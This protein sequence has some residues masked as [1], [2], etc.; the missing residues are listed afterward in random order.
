MFLVPVV[1]N[2]H[3]LPGMAAILLL[4]TTRTRLTE[5]LRTTFSLKLN[6]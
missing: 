3:R 4:E 6:F 1:F 2:L 5:L